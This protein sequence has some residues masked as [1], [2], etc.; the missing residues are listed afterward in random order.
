MFINKVLLPVLNNKFLYRQL[1]QDG[2]VALPPINADDIEKLTELFNVFHADLDDSFFHR[3][4]VGVHSNNFEYKKALHDAITQILDPYL[5]VHFTNFRRL[6]WTMQIKGTGAGSLV[7]LHQDWSVVD[8]RYFSSFTLWIALCDTTIENGCIHAIPQSHLL[9]CFPRGIALQGKYDS[10]HDDLLPYMKPY[11]C[12]AGT[13]LIF[14]NRLLHYSPPNFTGNFRVST[15]TLLVPDK[16]DTVLY[17]KNTN[18]PDAPI[19]VYDMED[20]FYLHFKD[21]LASQNACAPW[22]IKRAKSFKFK[23]YHPTLSKVLQK[24][25]FYKKLYAFY[26]IFNK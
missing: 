1:L 8:E 22:G 14:D 26:N 17:Y 11:A 9:P 23:E 6:V 18:V 16:A 7:P 10:L 15:I 20:D 3:F 4:H 5:H 2:I 24:L 21:F 25:F 19:E 12:K 13:M